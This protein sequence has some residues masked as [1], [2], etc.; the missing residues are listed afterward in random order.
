[1]RE[2]Y[3][4]VPAQPTP[5]GHEHEGR[6][7]LRQE[8]DAS[9]AAAAGR[10]TGVAVL[11]R[12]RRHQPGHLAQVPPRIYGSLGDASKYAATLTGHEL[13]LIDQKLDRYMAQKAEHA[14]MSHL[15]IDRFRFDSFALDPDEE[16]G[17]RLLTRFGRLVYMFFMITPPEATVERAGTP[18]SPGRPLQGGRRP[19]RAQ[20]RSL[21]RH[22]AAVLHLGRQEGQDRPLRVSRQRRA[23]KVRVRRQSRSAPTAR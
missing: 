14:G 4:L 22:A 1:M 21:H 11:E 16:E 5:G 6:I 7:G 17:S 13:T 20:C 8:H 18:R 15:L 9:T 19:A 23:P 12:L 10:G 2:G 3:L